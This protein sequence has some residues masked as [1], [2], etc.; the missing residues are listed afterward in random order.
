MLILSSEDNPNAFYELAIR[1]MEGRPVIHMTRELKIPF[2][3]HPYRTIQ[4][5]TAAYEDVE[6][7]KVELE[8]QVTEVLSSDYETDNPITTARGKKKWQESATSQD[9]YIMDTIDSLLSFINQLTSQMITLENR[10]TK[11]EHGLAPPTNALHPAS[12]E[13]SI[14]AAASHA[15]STG[16]GAL[17]LGTPVT[18]RSLGLGTPPKGR[19]KPNG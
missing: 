6:K 10:V 19:P 4:F 15:F 13:S 2:D 9:K 11:T 1:H 17:G 8:K 5:S 16:E 7:A 14:R 18:E 3:V 12:L